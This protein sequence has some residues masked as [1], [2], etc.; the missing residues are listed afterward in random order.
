MG[1]GKYSLIILNYDNSLYFIEIYVNG[2]T[3]FTSIY[4]VE[5]NGNYPTGS[6]AIMFRKD[7]ITNRL[8]GLGR[9]E[10]I[11]LD[12]CYFNRDGLVIRALDKN[13][14]SL[15]DIEDQAE[16]DKELKACEDQIV[17]NYDDH[18]TFTLDRAQQ[19]RCCSIQ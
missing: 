16:F 4:E 17:T 7:E 19:T 2:A 12:E 13:W 11:K 1:R 18:Q 3:D 5:A 14:A 15:V 9:R 6:K 8:Y 10:V